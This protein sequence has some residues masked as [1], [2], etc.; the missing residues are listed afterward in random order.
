M[1]KT[2]SVY[3]PVPE[4]LR[5]CSGSFLKT[6]A[7]VTML[8]DHIG[9]GIVYPLLASGFS[10]FSFSRNESILIYR[11]LRMIGRTA[12]PIFCFLL[13]EGFFHTKNRLRYFLNLFV[14][15]LLSEIPFDLAL[16]PANEWSNTLN[17]SE[18]LRTNLLVYAKDQNVYCTLFIGLLVIWAIDAV[19]VR[20]GREAANRETLRIPAYVIGALLSFL[21]VLAGYFAS[22]ALYTDYSHKGVILIVVLYLLYR[23]RPLA[24]GAGYAYISVFGTNEIWSLPGFVLMLLYNGKRGYIKGSL[25]YAFYAFYPVHLALIY[26]VRTF[27]L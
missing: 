2:M 11:L 23:I 26:V 6:V 21:A 1:Q 16:I 4:R 14:F 20:C 9:A 10:L 27:L 17:V 7:V 13:V 19:F 12:F 25:K 3:N 8:I 15:A 24:A 18:A 5:V 22:D